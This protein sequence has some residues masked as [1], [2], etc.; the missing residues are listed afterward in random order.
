[1][2]RQLPEAVEDGVAQRVRNDDL[3]DLLRPSPRTVAILDIAA[4]DEGAQD[5]LHEERIA[6]AGLEHCLT[7]LDGGWPTQTHGFAQECGDLVLTQPAK[8]KVLGDANPAQ[9][10]KHGPERMPSVELIAAVGSDEQKG[11]VAKLPCEMWKELE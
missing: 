4:L 8:P 3:G 5:L 10:S 1:M 9:L 7:K 11:Q 2:R 6:F